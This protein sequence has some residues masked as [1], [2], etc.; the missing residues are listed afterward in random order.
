[1]FRPT[2]KE[3]RGLLFEKAVFIPKLI[4]PESW[5]TDEFEF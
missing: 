4:S 1:M 2:V 5:Q 3:V